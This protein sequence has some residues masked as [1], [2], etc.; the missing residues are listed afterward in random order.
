[1]PKRDQNSEL[2]VGILGAGFISDFHA[3]ALAATEGVKL[4]A[5]A[6]LDF[7]KA[8][9]LARRHTA[10][11]AFPDLETMLESRRL[12]AVHVLLPPDVRGEPIMKVLEAGAHV[13]VEKPMA[14]SLDLC[15]PLIEH[16]RS[17]KRVLGVSHNFLFTPAYERLR[18]DLH[19]GRLGRVDELE[20]V[21]NK[22]LPQSRHGP[23]G[24]WMLRHPLNILFE[25]APHSLAHVLDLTTD[26]EIRE[27][28]ASNPL[29]MSNGQ[30]FFR[31]WWILMRAGET[32]VNLR[33]SFVEGYPEH[34][35]RVRGTMSSATCD[36]ERNL[37]NRHHH[38]PLPMD[39]DR[40]VAVTSEAAHAIRQATE[41]LTSYAWSKAV[42]SMSGSPFQGSITRCVQQFYAD[43]QRGQV[44]ERLSPRLG[45]AVVRLATE[46][47][48]RVD[49]APAKARSVRVE[50]KDRADPPVSTVL[51]TGGT[52]FIGCETVLALR[53]RG[54]GV[55]VLSRARS[56]P[57]QLAAA[58]VELHTGR[59]T[60]RRTIE[61]ALDG[62]EHCIHLARSHGQTWDEYRRFDVNTTGILA[63]TC[64]RLGV[65]RFVYASSIVIYDASDAS[66]VIVDDT[67]PNAAVTAS[68]AYAR[69]KVLCERFLRRMHSVSGFPVVIVRPGIVVGPQGN[70]CHWGVGMWPYH[71][72]CALWGEGDN[73][74][75]LVLVQDVAEA[76]V[77]C[78]EVDG[79]EGEAFN[80]VDEPVLTANDYLD[81]LERAAGVRI[82][83]H[84]RPVWQAYATDV[85]KWA[86]KT[87]IGHPHR[88]RPSL[89]A[90]KS[91]TA[92]AH[93]DCTKAKQKLGWSPAE[94]RQI[95]IDRGIVAPARVF[96]A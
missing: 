35:V 70:P 51:V 79:I 48:K 5:V 85:L 91:R 77:R 60:S 75:P 83:R 20:V 66:A 24:A 94:D 68:Q 76:I 81:E 13:M 14:H 74:L 54:Y 96:L 88:Q 26:V 34:R 29:E 61:R 23:F 31:R 6:D 56:L 32:E 71:S 92:A 86:A 22:F 17:V 25:I 78:I 62:I 12:D 65:R 95:I 16:A 63:R 57:P 18:R 87:L 64:E 9:G 11:T 82:A 47:A 44:D 27:V 41:T 4:V 52:G 7:D 28:E 72:V 67:P 43:L 90:C 55:R 93:F 80:L 50:T 8:R 59:L 38:R 42:G 37:Y 89:R 15:E 19:E 58:G 40:Y 21:W 73:R 30:V 1:V 69:S 45:T 53:R 46:V 2:E 3:N 36:F 33:F 10:A 49:L 39:F 84:V